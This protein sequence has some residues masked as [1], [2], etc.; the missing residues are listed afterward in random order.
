M[1]EKW[2]R[3]SLGVLLT[4]KALHGYSYLPAKV[5]LI[6]NDLKRHFSA[7]LPEKRE[8]P[9]QYIEKLKKYLEHWV[10]L[11]KAEKSYNGVRMC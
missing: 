10:E 11:S 2:L 5:S 4:G 9:E 8:N 1:E 7:I 6:L 3:V